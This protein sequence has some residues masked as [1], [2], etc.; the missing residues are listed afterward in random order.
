MHNVVVFLVRMMLSAT[1]HGGNEAL[2]HSCG[3][4]GCTILIYSSVPKKWLMILGGRGATGYHSS[5]DTVTNLT[6]GN[7]EVQLCRPR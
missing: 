5:T 7:E 1:L 3:I 6:T 2:G 4:A